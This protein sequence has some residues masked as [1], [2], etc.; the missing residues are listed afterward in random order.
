MAA[1][2]GKIL[3]AVLGANDRIRFAQLGYVGRGDGPP[4]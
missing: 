2:H 1:A 3:G 4:D